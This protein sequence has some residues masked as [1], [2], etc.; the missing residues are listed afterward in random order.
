MTICWC[1][2]IIDSNGVCKG[3]SGCDIIRDD[4]I[5]LNPAGF[6][7][8]IYAIAPIS[9]FITRIGKSAVSLHDLL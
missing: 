6:C 5:S 1:A 8:Y 4:Y 2:R 9:K 7:E 3:L